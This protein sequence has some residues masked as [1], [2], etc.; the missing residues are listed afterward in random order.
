MQSRAVVCCCRDLAYTKLL[1][2]TSR[3]FTSVTFDLR[4]PGHMTETQSPASAP[5]GRR[6]G[7]N[8]YDN[9]EQELLW[10]VVD[11]C[12]TLTRMYLCA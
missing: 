9:W 11:E 6:A 8:R 3:Y 4:L 5:A 7:E 12:V 10:L 2:F 1:Q